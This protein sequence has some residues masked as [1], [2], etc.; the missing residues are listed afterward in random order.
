MHLLIKVI[1][2]VNDGNLFD[3]DNRHAVRAREIFASHT[4]SYYDF[5]I[6]SELID[7]ESAAELSP[8]V[9]QKSGSGR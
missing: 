1:R 4:A 2:Y 5:L 7:I 3:S 6:R 8:E 9:F